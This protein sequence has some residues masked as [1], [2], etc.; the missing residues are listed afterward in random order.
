MYSALRFAIRKSTLQYFI[1]CG[2]WLTLQE[3]A[4]CLCGTDSKLCQC[5]YT[6]AHMT[7]AKCLLMKYACA[8][9]IKAAAFY[10]DI[11][12]AVILKWILPVLS[13]NMLY[14]SYSNFNKNKAWL[15]IN[16]PSMILWT[17]YLVRLLSYQ[18]ITV[19]KYNCYSVIFGVGWEV[20][21]EN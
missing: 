20:K 13:F 1:W 9:V 11:L 14:I 5:S 7:T 15:A 10:S 16:N 2:P 12:G 8:I 21:N 6:I 4:A 3:C 19:A 17:R 18:K